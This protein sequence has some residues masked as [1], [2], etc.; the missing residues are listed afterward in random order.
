MKNVLVNGGNYTLVNVGK[1]KLER[2]GYGCTW[3]VI[4]GKAHA[5][6]VSIGP[7]IVAVLTIQEGQVEGDQVAR[8]LS[9]AMVKKARRK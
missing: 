1:T 9:D 2:A 3:D 5:L 4:D 7:R 8:L 6:N